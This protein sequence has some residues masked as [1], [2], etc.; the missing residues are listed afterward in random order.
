MTDQELSVAI[1]E[2]IQNDRVVVALEQEMAQ[3]AV[4]ITNQRRFVSVANENRRNKMVGFG[5]VAIVLIGGVV[6]IAFTPDPR[7]PLTSTT[8]YPAISNFKATESYV[9][10]NS[11]GSYSTPAENMARAAV[12]TSL[13]APSSAKFGEA[14]ERNEGENGSCLLAVEGHV[15][16]QN[17]FGAMLHEPYRVLIRPV[18]GAWTVQSVWVGDDS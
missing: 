3:A 11:C 9:P 7:D 13:K 4:S 18:S 16:A 14:T 1:Q 5:F 6:R 12:L 17:S 2:A 10:A 15:D 8:S